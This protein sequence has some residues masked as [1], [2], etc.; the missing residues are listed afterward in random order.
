M[1]FSCYTRVLYLFLFIIEVRGP[2]RYQYEM[3]VEKRPSVCVIHVHLFFKFY[4]CSFSH[5][6]LMNQSHQQCK[7]APTGINSVLYFNLLLL[8]SANHK[9]LFYI[10]NPG[11]LKK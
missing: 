11:R 8:H 9:Y 4:F 2:P 1:I 7:S 10:V 5:F 3:I 6:P